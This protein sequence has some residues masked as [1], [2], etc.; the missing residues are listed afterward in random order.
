MRKGEGDKIWA[1]HEL[2]IIGTFKSLDRTTQG[3][4]LRTGKLPRKEINDA[5][6]AITLVI[7]KKLSGKAKETASLHD[8]ETGDLKDGL[9]IYKILSSPSTNDIKNLPMITAGKLF[10]DRGSNYPV[11]N[12]LLSSLPAKEHETFAQNV[13][14]SRMVLTPFYQPSIPI[15]PIL[16]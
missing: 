9:S 16:T 3:K 11:R 1:T 7:M 2:D 4:V 6:D 10:S 5:I 15:Y 13:V 14:P 8:T 12:Q